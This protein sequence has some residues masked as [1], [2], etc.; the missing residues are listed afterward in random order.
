M[1]TSGSPAFVKRTTGLTS[2]I[3]QSCNNMHDNNEVVY[4]LFAHLPTGK[5]SVWVVVGP[6]PGS[7]TADTL[8]V[9]F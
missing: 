2:P 6:E 7:L 8:Y 3:K 9:M 4:K 5:P 1:L